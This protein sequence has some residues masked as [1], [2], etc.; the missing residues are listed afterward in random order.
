M[1]ECIIFISYALCIASRGNCRRR[2]R[3]VCTRACTCVCVCI[4]SRAHER[5]RYGVQRET[6][7]IYVLQSDPEHGNFMHIASVGTHL[8]V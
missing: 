7:W 6:Y 1:N 8:C 4:C 5:D 2:R 3:G